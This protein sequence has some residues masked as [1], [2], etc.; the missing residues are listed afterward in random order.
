[1][2]FDA[3]AE[4]ARVLFAEEQIEARVRE[5]AGHVTEDYQDRDLV[6]VGVLKGAATL[7]VDLCRNIALPLA[8]DFVAIS[9]YGRGSTPG[10]PRLLKGLGEDVAGRDV[11]IVEDI[12]DSGATIAWLSDHLREQGPA[13][14]ES[15]VL[16]R[17]PA[18]DGRAVEPRYVGFDIEED[19][20][21]GY[22]ID[23]AERHRNLRSIHE[24]RLPVTA[25]GAGV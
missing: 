24:V 21:A 9:T 8:L 6:V 5:L 18:R 11:L 16:L 10:V 25:D 12:L 4:L 2:R 1:M 17:K 13:S 7:T 22:G 3:A 23:Y 14:V 19:W 20:V 15:C